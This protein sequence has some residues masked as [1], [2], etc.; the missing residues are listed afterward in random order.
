MIF[1]F[2]AVPQESFYSYP[3]LQKKINREIVLGKVL[4]VEER[5]SPYP[6]ALKE[7]V[8]ECKILGG[9][10]KGKQVEIL[11]FLSGRPDWDVVAK[12]GR[13]VVLW[14]E[15]NSKGE[16]VAAYILSYYREGYLLSLALIFVLLVIVFGRTVGARSLISLV[17]VFGSIIFVLFP[18]TLHGWNPLLPTIL[19]LVVVSI[20]TFILIAGFT[21]KAFAAI[22]GTLAGLLMSL[23]VSV[24]YAKL[25]HLTGLAT[26]EAKMLRYL[27]PSVKFSS[28]LLSSFLI[29]ALGAVMDVCI[30]IASGIREIKMANPSFGFRELLSSGLRIGRDILGTMT[31]TLVLAYTGS[32]MPLTL[33]YM[34]LN[35]GLFRS[36]NFEVAAVEITR[37]LVGSLAMLFAIP[38]TAFFSAFF[39]NDFHY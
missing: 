20:I 22:L 12:P 1:I 23:V 28:L 8:V 36:F 39:E 33:V 16:F 14:V 17:I 4:K 10:F 35:V 3:L 29:G 7:Q 31:N 2:C 13:K 15:K 9:T 26:T 11:N 27:N 21:R 25:M 18:L 19:I 24:V 32:L 6:G 34:G 38:L 37:A 30:S 5:E